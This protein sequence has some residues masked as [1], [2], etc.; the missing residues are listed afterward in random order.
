LAVERALKRGETGDGDGVHTGDGRSR[1][2][3][4]TGLRG[5]LRACTGGSFQACTRGSFRACTRGSF[6]ACTRGSFRA[7]SQGLLPAYTRGSV[8]KNAPG[9]LIAPP[10]AGLRQNVAS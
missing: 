6:R 10:H 7:Y 1:P 8:V 5:L 9:A 2:I 4:V 3:A